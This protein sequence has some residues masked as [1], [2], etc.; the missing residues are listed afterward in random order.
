MKLCPFHL[1][2]ISGEALH[3][4]AKLRSQQ[5]SIRPKKLLAG[6]AFGFLLAAPVAATEHEVSTYG[7]LLDACYSGSSESIALDA[8]IGLMATA[9]M[10]EQEGGHSTLGMTSCLNAEAEVWDRFLNIEYR[11]TRDWAKAADADEAEHF[12]EF[13]VR[14]EKLLAAQRAWIAYRDAECALDYAEWGSGSMRNIAFADCMVHMT[15][16]RTIELRQM[17]E[18]FQ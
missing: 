14:A 4:V 16:K 8:C 2:C 7:P 1:L 17:R 5:N 9:C 15:A 13:A 11:A 12:P 10:D 6:L 3:Q 18:M